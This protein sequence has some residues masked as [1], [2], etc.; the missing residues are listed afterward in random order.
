[1]S[2][3]GDE[4]SLCKS[5]THSPWFSHTIPSP[6]RRR[7]VDEEEKEREIG[8]AEEDNAGMSSFHTLMV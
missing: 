3:G 7:G 5:K 2:G 1:V 6:R 8:A 4:S